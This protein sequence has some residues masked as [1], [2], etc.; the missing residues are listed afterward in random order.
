MLRPTTG[1]LLAG[2]SASLRQS[3][4][5]ALPPGDAQRQV[6]AALH[7]LDRLQRT[8]DLALP[9][10]RTDNA[11]MRETLQGILE[12]L[13]QLQPGALPPHLDSIR[14]SFAP[15]VEASA[16]ASSV[17]IPGINERSLKS[18]A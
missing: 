4:L 17:E 18:E 15:T 16:R 7:A 5:T 6:K 2:L 9:H 1:E 13:A 11:D 3:V 10:L 8:W 14:V 12:A